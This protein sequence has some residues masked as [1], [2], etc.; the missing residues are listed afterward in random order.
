MADDGD[1]PPDLAP[2]VRAA[3]ADVQ[4]AIERHAR[5]RLAAVELRAAQLDRESTKRATR[6]QHDAE[7]RAERIL[8]AALEHASVLL[9]SVEDGRRERA[10]TVS[11][12]ESQVMS[13]PSSQLRQVVRAA[14]HKMR[15]EGR[16]RGDAERFLVRFGLA[17]EHGDELATS[18]AP[19]P[20]AIP[21]RGA[22]FRGCP[23]A[24]GPDGPRPKG[25]SRSEATDQKSG[26]SHTRALRVFIT[27]PMYHSA[28]SVCQRPA[29]HAPTL[30]H[31]SPGA[32][33]RPRGTV[34]SHVA[35]PS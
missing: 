10:E 18:T 28:S 4:A 19:A 25:S 31:T 21:V 5:D 7:R 34:F 11:G 6:L 14:L 9:D 15:E 24:A 3:L 13:A 27:R 8:Q 12:I 17:E 30:P 22:A 1:T 29:Y 26:D 35:H 23:G 33:S 32:Y 16:P 20:A 2:E